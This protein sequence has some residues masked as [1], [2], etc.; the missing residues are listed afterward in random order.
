MGIDVL[1]L[2]YAPKLVFI[3]LNTLISLICRLFSK[4][5]KIGLYIG[6]SVSILLFFLILYSIT[7]GKI[8]Y[9]IET[10]EIKI[11]NLPEAF[12][13][14]QIIQLSDMHLG[15]LSTCSKGI[16]RLV[17]KI[18]AMEPDLIVFTGDMVNNFAAEMLPWIEELSQ[19]KAKYG[20]FAIMGNHDYGDYTQWKN[21]ADKEQNRRDF[22][23]YIAQM[24]F[25][26]L[27]NAHTYIA[28]EGDTLYIAGVENWG[29]PPFPQYGN[30]PEAIEGIE[31]KCMVFMTHDPSHWRAE[32]LDYNIPLTL[33]GHTHAMQMGFKFGNFEWSPSKY[34]YPEYDGLYKEGNQ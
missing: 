5:R 33:S 32:I 14:F 19:L 1:F 22:D 13:N 16:G 31:D 26:M 10:T 3:I 6:G 20:K 12:D 28:L 4:N 9:K 21:P 18:N 2:F 15:S 24:G 29:K 17:K 8:N 23:A 34:I 27:N 11:D 7:V 25:T 30:L